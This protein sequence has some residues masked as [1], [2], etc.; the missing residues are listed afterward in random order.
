MHGCDARMIQQVD[1]NYNAIMTV[2][3]QST[4]KLEVL[5][6]SHNVVPVSIRRSISL[7]YF[8]FS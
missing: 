6:H 7:T 1:T 3:L 4:V 8:E 5:L 2:V